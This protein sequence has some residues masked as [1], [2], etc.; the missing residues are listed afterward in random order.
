MTLTF[1]KDGGIKYIDDNSSWI[2]T[3][4]AEGW[5]L[6]GDEPEETLES[7]RAKADALG[8]EY[9][10]NYGVKKLKELI[11]GNNG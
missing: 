2:P 3:L 4:K 5:V 1:R 9:R 11:D 8:I 7:L 6:E 10:I